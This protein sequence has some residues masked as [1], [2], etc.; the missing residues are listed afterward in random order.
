M[1]FYVQINS[2][3]HPWYKSIIGSHEAYAYSFVSYLTVTIVFFFFLLFTKIF[4]VT[5]KSLFY[6]V[7][8]WQT[9]TQR[10]TLLTAF[11]LEM[12]YSVCDMHISYLKTSHS[13]LVI[14]L[15]VPGGIYTDWL[16]MKQ[17]IFEVANWY[18][19]ISDYNIKC[20]GKKWHIWNFF[21]NRHPK[22]PQFIT[23]WYMVL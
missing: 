2:L 23:V 9:C 8:I 15:Y 6:G 13:P 3:Y 17:F 18:F 10:C 7:D 12:G 5:T 4:D 11:F 14:E 22:I 20:I 1:P 19:A 16:H 21:S